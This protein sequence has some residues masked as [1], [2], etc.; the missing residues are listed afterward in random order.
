MGPRSPPL[1][2]LCA[3]VLRGDP[4]GMLW[5]RPNGGYASGGRWQWWRGE[6]L[7]LPEAEV[8]LVAKFRH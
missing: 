5:L 1:L 3:C 4:G 8:I 7:Q 2:S 6:Q